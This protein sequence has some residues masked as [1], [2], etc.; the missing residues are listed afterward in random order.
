MFA[1]IV[2][3]SVYVSC[4]MYVCYGMC[5]CHV[6][7]CI[8]ALICMFAMVWCLLW[9]M[10]VCLLWYV[11]F[12][13]LYFVWYVLFCMLA[14]KCDVAASFQLLRWGAFPRCRNRKPWRVRR[15][16]LLEAWRARCQR[17]TVMEATRSRP[18]SHRKSSSLPLASRWKRVRMRMRVMPTLPPAIRAYHGMVE[19]TTIVRTYYLL[20]ATSLASLEQINNNALWFMFPKGKLSSFDVI[21]ELTESTLN[22]CF[23][24]R[25][26]LLLYFGLGRLI[27]AS[28]YSIFKINFVFPLFKRTVCMLF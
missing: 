15:G 26:A 8:V 13:I 20:P 22:Q 24:G 27:S 2:T 16:C 25:L 19:L 4:G 7:V 5:V 6:M 9:Y 3:D 12:C 28:M 21:W 11:L 14:A 23:I 17:V 18:P 1:I 10:Y